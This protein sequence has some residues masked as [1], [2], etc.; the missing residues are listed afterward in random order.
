MALSCAR[1]FVCVC[2]FLINYAIEDRLRA[3]SFDSS[4]MEG[5]T[6]VGRAPY[7]GSVPEP[8]LAGRISGPASLQ[9]F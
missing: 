9:P 6:A 7:S 2:G 8:M 1:Q 3:V 4:P 5:Q